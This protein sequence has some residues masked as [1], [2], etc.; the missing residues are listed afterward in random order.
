MRF[1]LI[2]RA[3]S[4]KDT[5]ADYL[6]ER[7]GFVKLSF[8]AKLKAIAEEMF[9]IS[10]QASRRRLLQDLGMKFREIEENCWVDYL[11][12]QVHR[13]Q[14]VVITDC[15]YDNEYEICLISNFIPAKIDCADKVRAERLYKRDGRRM[16]AQEQSHISEQLNVPC[17]YHLDNNYDLVTLYDQIER[18]VQDANSSA[19]YSRN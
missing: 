8:A 3:G 15:R 1:M 7:H 2:G 6:V 16:T 5:V 4:G 14:K 17:D 10:W 9:P 12:R 11:L 19:N 18:M 13:Y